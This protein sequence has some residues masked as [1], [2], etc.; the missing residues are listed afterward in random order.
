MLGI[1]NV[2]KNE[3]IFSVISRVYLILV[4]IIVSSF[5]VRFLGKDLNGRLS[6]IT[7]VSAIINMLFLFGFTQSY[8]YL[9]KIGDEKFPSLFYGCSILLSLIY[10]ILSVFV[11]LFVGVRGENAVII[12]T[13][14]LS[15]SVKIAG[16]LSL[17]ER[18]TYRNTVQMIV[19]TV[20]MLIMIVLFIAADS[21]FFW[22]VFIFTF[23]DVLSLILYSSRLKVKPH[24]DTKSLARLV[25]IMKFGIVPMLGV[26]LVNLNYRAD[27][28]MLKRMMDYSSVSIYS[29]G[30]GI[31]EQCWAIPE[32]IREILLYRLTKGK[33]ADEVC[34]MLRVSNTATLFF[35]LGLLVAGRF[36]IVL[37][38]GEDYLPSVP[39]LHL[40]MISS[41]GMV[42]TKLIGAY[43]ITEGK[44]RIKTFFLLIAAAVNICFNWC[45]IPKYGIYGAIYASII[46]YTLCGLLFI[47]L[48]KKIADIHVGDILFIRY[49]DIIAICRMIGRKK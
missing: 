32:A 7:G 11:C 17:I 1:R 6:Y 2:L 33:N 42:F 21:S 41:Y 26:F 14:S 19:G 12:L 45:L 46:S 24:I 40:A 10:L 35:Q 37:L 44:Q 43:C 5:Q 29:T 49:N 15:Y 34:C 39:I 23:G 16:S 18:P 3:Y 8:P 31:A 30:V 22:M 47:G 13:I 27:V 4:G 9:K 38:Y 48:F 20:K 36:A 25:K 28:Y